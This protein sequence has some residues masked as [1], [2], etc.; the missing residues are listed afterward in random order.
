MAS[1]GH[2]AEFFEDGTFVDLHINQYEIE[3]SKK[4]E[5]SATDTPPEDFQPL[6]ELL[7]ELPVFSEYR[8]TDIMTTEHFDSLL[9]SAG[10]EAVYGD[11]GMVEVVS[12]NTE[13]SNADV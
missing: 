9:A 8:V 10:Y 1:F 13:V 12:K 4:G 6:V 11:D 3:Q 2:E 5:A 7:S